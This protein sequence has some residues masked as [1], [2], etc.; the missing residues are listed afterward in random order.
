LFRHKGNREYVVPASCDDQCSSYTTT[1][2][3]N[4]AN[5]CVFD[6]SNVTIGNVTQGTCTQ[7]AY[8]NMLQSAENKANYVMSIPYII[9]AVI[10]PFLGFG[11]DLLGG[12]A[13]LA[14]VAPLVLIAVHSLL[15]FT[16]ITP[17]VPLVGQGL[18]YSV[19]AAALWPS[20]PYVVDARYVGTGSLLRV[21]YAGVTASHAIFVL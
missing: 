12:R 3:C 20:V 6:A 17:Y 10:S 19:F 14:T 16:S 21:G 2:E 11:V 9:S 15:G 5:G 7:E 13:I 18:A 8:C 1:A 4:Y